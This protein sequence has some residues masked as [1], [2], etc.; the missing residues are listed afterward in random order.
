MLCLPQSLDI[1]SDARERGEAERNE[2]GGG[3]PKSL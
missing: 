3:W 1:Q 2:D